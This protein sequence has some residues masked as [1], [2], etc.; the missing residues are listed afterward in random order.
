MFV[1]LRHVVQYTYHAAET[2]NT[3]DRYWFLGSILFQLLSGTKLLH[4]DFITKMPQ[5]SLSGCLL[6]AGAA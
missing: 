5:V 4:K 2:E 6:I 1:F 3:K